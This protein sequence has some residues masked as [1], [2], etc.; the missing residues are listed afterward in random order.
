MV[1]ALLVL[2]VVLAAALPAAAAT[3]I[4]DVLDGS[5]SPNWVTICI[6]DTVQWQWDDANSIEYG[7]VSDTN[8]YESWNS[9][10]LAPGS[11]FS[12]TFT[13]VGTFAY[14]GTWEGGFPVQG[15]KGTVEVTDIPEPAGLLTLVSFACALGGA[16]VRRTR[17]RRS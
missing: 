16:A 7:C 17:V 5:F 15:M 4:V 14:H 10:E 9:G 6:N 1:K 13:H 11:T 2:A 8:P 3:A 12:H